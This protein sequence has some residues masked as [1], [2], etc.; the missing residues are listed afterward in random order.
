MQTIYRAFLAA[1]ALALA[2]DALAQTFP[3]RPVRIIVP[4]PA[5]GPSDILTRM[6]SP[7]L[8]DLWGQQVVVDNRPGAGTII[9]TDLLAKAARGK[10]RA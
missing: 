2:A 7:K 8:T 9:G 1:A 4:F 3:T 5:G 6:M 10:A